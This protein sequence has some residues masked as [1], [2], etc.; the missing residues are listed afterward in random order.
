MTPVRRRFH[1]PR[2]IRYALVVGA[3]LVVAAGLLLPAINRVREAAARC[4]CTCHLKCLSLALHNSAASAGGERFPPGTVQLRDVPPERRLSWMVTVLPY[5]EQNRALERFDLTAAAD[6]ER[7]QVALDHRIPAF[8][9]P[10]SGEYVREDRV[11]KWKSPAPLTHYVGVS[12]A[13]ADAATLPVGHPRAGVFGYDR[14]MS[15]R[16]DFPD[17]TGNT[18]LLMETANAPGHWAVG[19]PA[20][21]RGIEA[22]THPYVGRGR[23]FGGFHPPEPW[24]FER[25]REQDCNVAMADASIRFIRATIAPE[26]LEA[27]ATAGGREALPDGW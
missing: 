3:L 20:T 9:C 4:V 16:D 6:D 1:V 14:Q 2:P 18:L 24:I 5:I 26:V 10:S 21:V 22:A 17:G 13:G 12:G 23:P 25:E 11:G 27:L 7:N 15:W 19:G 8:V